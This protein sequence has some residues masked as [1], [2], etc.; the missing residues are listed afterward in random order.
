[1][2]A[3][4]LSA[5]RILT[6]VGYVGSVVA[7]LLLLV[8]LP[9]NLPQ[10]WSNHLWMI[11][12]YGDYFRAHGSLPTVMNTGP[13]VG[14]AQPVFY[15]WLFYPWLG[16]LAAATGAALAVRVAVLAMLAG[17]FIALVSTGRKIFG[18]SRLAYVVAVSMVWGTYSLTNLYSRGALAEYF[19]TGFFV[20]ALAWGTGAVVAGD[21]PSRWFQGWL[22]GFFLLLT[23]GTH[24]PTAVLAAAFVAMLAIGGGLAGGRAAYR[25]CMGRGALFA[26][27]GFFAGAIIVAPWVY[28]NG[29]F[30]R[31][32]SLVRSGSA[33]IFIP[34]KCDT[35]WG[36]LAP[37]PYDASA[38][39]NG[40][41]GLGTAYLEAPI[42]LVLLGLLLWNLELCRR[43]RADGLVPGAGS[44]PG[45]TILVLACGWFLFLGLL[46]VSPWFAGF[47]QGLA[48]YVQYV[49]RLVSHCSA[50]LLVAVFVSGAWVA[51]QGGYRRH[52]HETALIVGVCL[53]VAILGL[54]IKLQHASVVI[55]AEGD[56]PASVARRQR[57]VVPDYTVP[58][59]V[60]ELSGAELGGAAMVSFP[61]GGSG[62]NF[63]DVGAIQVDQPHAGWVR[64]NAVVFPWLKLESDRQELNGDRLARA[65]HFLAVYLPPGRSELRAVWQ[66]DRTW[67]LLNRL[68]RAVFALVLLG[69][70]GWA[71]ARRF[72]RRTAGALT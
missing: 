19:A 72:G 6:G 42:N 23:A 59:S 44:R 3:I 13:A 51:R 30:A 20:T 45:K 46:S 7:P 50:A 55:A 17:Q 38:A 4:G 12:Y 25:Q 49:Y 70:L 11:G 48:P 53:T 60:R 10:D 54:G 16:I 27:G 24:A 47:F 1:M 36:R 2:S 8:D 71:M 34:E 9:A 26:A 67:T 5:R 31:K 64:T 43:N 61:V 35:L 63:G 66:P 41:F 15:A 28:A 21:R 52:S 69:T 33:F 58:A 57:E 56:R 68:S 32:L 37:L 29:L 14:L 65:D 18:E 62:A 39:E 40:N 22:A